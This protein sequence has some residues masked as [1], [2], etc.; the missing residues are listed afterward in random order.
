[1]GFHQT[2]APP[3]EDLRPIALLSWAPE[4]LEERRGI[5]FRSGLDDLDTYRY[6]SIETDRGRHF[7]LLRYDRNPQPGTEVLA[8]A[9]GR[10]VDD[11]LADFLAAVDIDRGHVV[12]LA[13][14]PRERFGGI[15]EAG[16]ASV[17][18]VLLALGNLLAVA[19]GDPIFSSSRPASIAS[20]ALFVIACLLLAA[21]GAFRRG[22]T[23]REKL[24]GRDAQR[25]V[26]R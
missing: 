21:S 9:Q 1:M 10:D 23:F 15:L 17:A 24:E 18:F 25:R 4:E 8:Q 12:W 2:A 20:V 14:G 6:A 13:T 5:E 3:E 11:A 16:R 26:Q 22:I 19:F 7:A